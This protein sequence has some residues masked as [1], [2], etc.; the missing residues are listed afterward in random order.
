MIGFIFILIALVF[1]SQ[2]AGLLEV[3]PLSVLG[4]LLVFAGTQ[5]ALTILDVKERRDLFVVVAILGVSLATNLAIGF[6]VGIVLAY[7][8]KARILKV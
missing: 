6:G 8:F 4:A 3:L 1:G 7:A 5:L 2:A